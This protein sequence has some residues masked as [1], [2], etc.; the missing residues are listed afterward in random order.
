MA[1]AYLFSNHNCILAYEITFLNTLCG[2][3]RSSQPLW[4]IHNIAYISFD[5]FAIDES[6][7]V[8]ISRVIM[9]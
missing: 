6:N 2:I 9:R 4:K 5:C 3:Y 8:K 7:Q 1:A